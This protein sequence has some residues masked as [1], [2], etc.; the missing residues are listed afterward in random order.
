MLH[1]VEL[2]P[3]SRQHTRPARKLKFVSGSVCAVLD[4]IDSQRVF[5][6]DVDCEG[7]EEAHAVAKVPFVVLDFFFRL[8]RKYC[9]GVLPSP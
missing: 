4:P 2:L 5:W 7:V 8:N 9:T 6:P 3:A 1:D